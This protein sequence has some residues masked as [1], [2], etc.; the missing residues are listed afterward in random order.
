M[1]VL[2]TTHAQMYQL[3]DGSIWTSA[4]YG[5]D[6][7]KRYLKVFDKVRL[8]TRLKKE[9]DLDT[10]KLIRVD[11]DGLE[12]YPLPFYVGPWEYAMNYFKIKQSLEQAISD[13]DCAILRIPD[14]LPF[15]IFRKLKK[16]KIPC[17]VEVVAHSWDILAPGT[18][19]TIL[20]PLLRRYWDFY[21]KKLCKNADG[22]SYVT[23]DYL[24]RRYPSGISKDDTNRFEAVYTSADLSLE[25]FESF[26]PSKVYNEKIFK[27]VHISTINNT[28]KGH[29]NLLRIIKELNRDSAKYYLTFVGGGSLLKFYK[30]MASTMQ[31]DRYVDFVGHVPTADGITQILINSDIF[32]LPTLAEGLPRVIL[33]AMATGLPCIANAVG[34]IPEIISSEFLVEPNNDTMLKNKILEISNNKILLSGE[35]IKN[36]N[37]IMKDFLPEIVQKRRSEFYMKLKKN[38]I[39]K[40]NWSGK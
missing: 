39:I 22:V 7:F 34:G 38:V 6:F 8:V 2:I 24:Q 27:L 29:E 25:F 23:K 11:G 15:Q 12:V 20:R 40:D 1:K 32:V 26:T 37:T 9:N 31:L 36:H 16:K 18:T 3:E 14:Q 5:Y 17:A 21:Q 19:K 28:A 30:D 33:E 10:K 4:T 35:R 13:C